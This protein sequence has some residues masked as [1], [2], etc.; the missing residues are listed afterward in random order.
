MPTPIPIQQDFRPKAIMA[1]AACN[2][3]AN[4]GTT[5][6][7]WANNATVTAVLAAIRALPL[8]PGT[9]DDLKEKGAIGIQYGNDAGVIADT[10]GF[11]TL[12]GAETAVQAYIP[13]YNASFDG[14]LPQ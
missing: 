9:S 1:L 12:V 8:K 13:D 4:L 10:H 5:D 3:L 11:T 2:I 6:A 7:I 14:F